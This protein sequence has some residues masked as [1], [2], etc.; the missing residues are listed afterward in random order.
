[1]KILD[2]SSKCTFR[3]WKLSVP[4]KIAQKSE[5]I[6]LGSKRKQQPQDSRRTYWMIRTSWRSSY[7]W[8]YW[9][10]EAAV[11]LPCEQELAQNTDR[12]AKEPTV[13]KWEAKTPKRTF[14]Q[15]STKA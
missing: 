13:T 1:M 6:G 3:N 8:I 4:K 11:L 5:K 2:R 7:G 10:S 12:E 15:V 9:E 14:P